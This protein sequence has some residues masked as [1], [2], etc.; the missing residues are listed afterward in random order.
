MKQ[1]TI[2]VDL[3]YGDAG[4]GSMVDYY[5]R[6]TGATTVI[7]FNGGAQAGHRVVLPDGRSHIFSQFGS[8]TFVDG[9]NTH[10]SRYMLVDPISM[11][12]EAKHLESLGVKN[13][14]DRITIDANCLL[15]TPFQRSANRIKETIRDKNRHGSCGMGIGETMSDLNNKRQVIRA[16]DLKSKYQLKKKMKSLQKDKFRDVFQFGCIDKVNADDMEILTVKDAI[17]EF[18]D[19]FYDFGTKVKVVNNSYTTQVLQQE[20]VVFEGAQGVL[21]D[22]WYG[23]HP[24]TTWS[25]TTFRNALRLL[26]ENQYDGHIHK[27]GLTRAYMTRH[28]PGPFVTEDAEL[29]QHF[30]DPCNKTNDWQREFRVGNLDLLALKYALQV[31]G[32]VDGIAMTCMDRV[33]QESHLQVCCTYQRQSTKSYVP[34]LCSKEQ[35][36]NHQEGLTKLLGDCSPILDK[37]SISELPFTI[38]RFLKTPICAWSYGPTHEDKVQVVQKEYCRA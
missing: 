23:F 14:L 30:P 8:G 17:G 18:A 15:V 33:A 31:C 24:Y 28:G 35:D 32:G 25:T 13:P 27:I 3:G 9:V 36:L 6:L 2:V 19:L 37:I 29:T 26:L 21:I 22:E 1:A 5:T 4:K 7:R 12:Q 38:E 20:S 10:L 34:I 16:S 11:I